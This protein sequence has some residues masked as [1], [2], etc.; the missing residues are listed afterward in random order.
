M[1]GKDAGVKGEILKVIKNKETN[2]IE[3]VVVKDANIATINRKPNPLL[4]INGEQ[5]KVERPLNASNVMLLDGDK[6]TR[7]KMEDGKRVSVKSGKE[8]K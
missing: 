8:I 6:P 1:R 2:K 4:G 5:L 7:V 3:K